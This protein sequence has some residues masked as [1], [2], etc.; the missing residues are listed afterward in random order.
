MADYYIHLTG[1]S[2]KKL[3]FEAETENC[4]Y[5]LRTMKSSGVIHLFALLHALVALVCQWGGMDDALTLTILTMTM[6]VIL[7]LK[8]G[9]PIDIVAVMVI[10]VNVVGFVVGTVGAELIRHLVHVELAA[11]LLATALTTE[12]LGWTLVLLAKLTYKING[13]EADLAR[14]DSKL[15]WALVIVGVIFALRIGAAMLFATPL[16]AGKNVLVYA[17]EILSSSPALI[18]YVCLTIICVRYMRRTEWTKLGW[19]AWT[20]YVVAIVAL[21]AVGAWC[22]GIAA[23]EGRWSVPFEEYLRYFI[24]SVLVETTIC[25]IVILVDSVFSIRRAMHREREKAAQAQY[26]YVKLKQQVNPHFLF[27]SLNTLDSLVC[28]GHTQQASDYIHRLAHMYRYMLRSEEEGLV[29]LREEVAF[30]QEYVALQ[31]VRFAGGFEVSYDIS[32]EAMRRMVVPCAV[33]LLVENA[34]KHNAVSEERPLMITISATDNLLTIE[35]NVIPKYT[36]TLST[37]LGQKYIREQYRSLTTQE[38]TIENDG[39]HY[40]VV[41]PLL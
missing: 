12:L 13:V 27:N 35:N 40:R 34:I 39:V 37:G 26:R 15:R 7:C 16:Y 25:C 9:M 33:Q 4:T 23:E 28:D 24:A 19:W 41:V 17:W 32:H 3:N 29:C 31:K 5:M 14:S 22:F 18:T 6:T 36:R 10:V 1:F 2:K 11:R 30:I 38:V 20:A 8:K 21:S